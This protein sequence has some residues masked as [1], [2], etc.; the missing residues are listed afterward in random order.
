MKEQVFPRIQRTSDL[1][2]IVL[3]SATPLLRDVIWSN[4]RSI[5]WAGMEEGGDVCVRYFG[6][7]DI[8]PI[9]DYTL[10]RIRPALPSPIRY[11]FVSLVL[12]CFVSC[13]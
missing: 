12:S 11:G 9:N 7:V 4:H 5:D 8:Q 6:T 10:D 13:S 2:F 3:V 1:A